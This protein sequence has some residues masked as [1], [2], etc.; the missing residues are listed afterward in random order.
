MDEIKIWTIDGS[1][2]QEIQPTRQTESE[3]WLEENIVSKPELL[4]PGLTL[5]GRQTQTE[6]GPLDLLGVDSD[7]R[8]VLFELKRGTLSRDAVAQ[9]VDYASDLEGM[10]LDALANHL[11]NRSGTSGIEKIEDF[12][13]W[14]TENT[15]ADALEDLLHTHRL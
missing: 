4:M 14:H 9:I 5:V 12:K 13:E 1:D 10:N 11:A 7:G 6:G 15:G 2:V 8:L 3:Q